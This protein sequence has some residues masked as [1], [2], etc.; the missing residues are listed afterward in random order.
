[1]RSTVRRV[2]TICALVFTFAAISAALE[3]PVRAQ[4]PPSGA[5]TVFTDGLAY[6]DGVIS[7]ALAELSAELDRSG[8]VRLLSVM[9]NAGAANVRDLLRFRG[10]DFAIL[11]SDVFAS[12][13]VA[14]TYPEATE[15]LRYVTKLRTQKLVLLARSDIDAVEQLAGKK[16]AVVGPEAVT[17]LTAHTVFAA[18][19]IGAEITPLQDA[20]A[21][22]QL[23][24]AAAV[25]F[26]D[27][28]AKRLPES[29]ARSGEFHG[30]AIPMNDTLSKFYRPAQIQPGEAAG[31]S[32]SHSIA[33]IETDT[34]LASFNW[35]PQHVRYADVAAFINSFFAA[36]PDLRR[37]RSASIW[38]ETDPRAPVLGWRQHPHAAVASKS[39]PALAPVPVAAAA[40]PAAP[41]IAPDIEDRNSE[42][43]LKLSIVPQPPLTDDHSSGGGLVTELTRA[44]LERMDWPHAGDF[45]VEWD[46]DRESQVHRVLVEKRADLALLWARPNCEDPGL[47][48]GESAAF[49]DGALA[50][51]PIFKALVV[52]FTRSGSDFDPAS[53]DRLA[54]RSICVPANRDVAPPTEVA[55]KMVRDGRLKLVRP[56]SLIDCL[57]IVGRG[58]ADALLVNE[59]EGKLAISRLGL[60]QAFRM[61]ENAGAAQEVRI[62]VPKD[63]PKAKE[64]L[65]A[66]NKGIA[67]LKSE[68]LYSQIVMKH[69]LAL[70]P[71]A[72]TQ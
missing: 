4:T 62:V 16:V 49:C 41:A 37:D 60:S 21:E 10:V 56:Q 44:A 24:E 70:N 51:E 19:G 2:A 39:V 59:L 66:L 12:A 54:G 5:V 48:T 9:G 46:K 17:G 31:N 28:D 32:A 69:V 68:D 8:K 25:F 43:R 3:A 11:N 53:E 55:K 71:P 13:R 35:V 14:K 58:E 65:G 15:K 57:N 7:K 18:L 6:P 20:S 23:R 61:V 1:M 34:I 30:V 52:F 36:I 47:L 40:A 26:I 38:N 45:E 64:L 33:T 27:T 67:K 42:Q 22:E 63:A 50:S 72:T 29:I